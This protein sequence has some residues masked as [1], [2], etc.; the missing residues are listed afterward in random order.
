MWVATSGLQV[1]DLRAKMI[2]GKMTMW[3]VYPPRDK[4][5]AE[6]NQLGS[7]QWERISYQQDAEGTWQPQFR[8]VPRRAPCG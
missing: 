2:D 7:D 1:Q 3:Q 8:L 5:K 6:F 4:W